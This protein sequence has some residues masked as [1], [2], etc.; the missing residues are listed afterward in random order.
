V[1]RPRIYGSEP[2]FRRALARYIKSG[3]A[4]IDESLKIR[5]GILDAELLAELL[6]FSWDSPQ[7]WYSTT[8]HGLSK[9]LHGVEEVLPVLCAGVPSRKPKE[10]REP[11][12]IKREPAHSLKELDTWV[13]WLSAA[14]DELRE[15]QSVIG[16]RRGI[17]PTPVTAA[18][19]EELL[20]SGLVD[21]QV[22]EDHARDMCGPRTPKQL[23]TAIGAAKELTEATLRAAIDHCGES[24]KSGDDLGMLMKTWRNAM[25][26][27]GCPRPRGSGGAVE[28]GGCVG[29]P[30]HVPRRMAESVRTRPWTEA[31]PA[32]PGR[33]TRST[34]YRHRRDRDPVHRD[35][36][37]RPSTAAATPKRLAP[38]GGLLHQRW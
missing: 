16:V 28:G 34:C 6:I 31:L 19:F 35:D 4:V 13:S 24:W 10:P 29:E 21:H 37:G 3:N 26:E 22:I 8:R 33:S 12:G 32:R 20:A 36:H 18:R 9:Y 27:K 15:L 2:N 1:K 11:P 14:R 17:A 5:Q 30:G 38:V 7:R 23:A 25:H